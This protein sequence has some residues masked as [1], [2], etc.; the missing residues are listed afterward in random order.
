MKSTKPKKAFARLH[1]IPIYGAHL[2]IVLADDINPERKRMAFLFGECPTYDYYCLCSY[3]HRGDFAIFMQRNAG[4]DDDAHEVFHCTHRIMEH[5]NCNFDPQHHEQGALLC[6]Y[7][8]QL[9]AD[10]RAADKKGKRK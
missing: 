9:L 10:C 1:H 3:N 2:W 7:L 6:G 8:S 5:C 4:V